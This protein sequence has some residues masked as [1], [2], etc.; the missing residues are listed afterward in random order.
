[1][2]ALVDSSVRAA[3]EELEVIH[4]SAPPPS[5]RRYGRH[6]SVLLASL[7]SSESEVLIAPQ[8]V[9]IGQVLVR[10]QRIASNT[11]Q[12]LRRPKTRRALRVRIEHFASV[13]RTYYPIDILR[14]RLTT[15][16]QFLQQRIPESR[17]LVPDGIHLRRTEDYVFASLVHC[18]DCHARTH[19][20]WATRM[21]TAT[22]IALKDLQAAEATGTPAELATPG[23][24][25]DTP[26][27]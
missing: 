8:V 21:N 17:R 18:C 24:L 6:V 25:T 16:D 23:A 11:R 2:L 22:G 9:E 5:S 26:L 10:W 27:L 14:S 7:R 4:E 12:D 13:G 1:M 15:I 3:I 20:Q 19:L